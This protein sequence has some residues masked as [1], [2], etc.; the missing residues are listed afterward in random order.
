MTFIKLVTLHS[1]FVYHRCSSDNSPKGS[2]RFSAAALESFLPP[3]VDR[4]LRARVSGVGLE[5]VDHIL[6]EEEILFPIR[7]AGQ[8]SCR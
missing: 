6:I 5:L 7:L 3:K 4:Y 8:R 2:H 1:S